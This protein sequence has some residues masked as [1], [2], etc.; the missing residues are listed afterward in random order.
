[1]DEEFADRHELGGEPSGS[2]LASYCR[3]RARLFLAVLDE[4]ALPRGPLFL[5]VVTNVTLGCGI[6]AKKPETPVIN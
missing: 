2:G 6:L 1:M 5:V 4:A 3:S